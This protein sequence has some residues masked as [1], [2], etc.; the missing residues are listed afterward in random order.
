MS[1]LYLFLSLLFSCWLAVAA[2]V[3]RFGPA[4]AG[5]QPAT[6]SP[7]ERRELLAAREAVWRAWF[8]N[9]QAHLEAV[10]PEETIAINAGEEAWQDRRAVLESA[11][12]FAAGGQ[13][14][15]ALEYPRTEMQVYGDV[16]I[17][18]TLYR[19]EL[20]GNG[21]RGVTAGRGTEIFV[22]RNGRWV[23]SGWHLDSGQ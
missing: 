14:L 1:A 10:I 9:D 15:V 13:R 8:A 2:D 20:E 7:A 16:A 19:F 22:R 12:A 18:Y 11:Q 21:Q 6:L 5:S 17:L 23:N 4:S 3:P